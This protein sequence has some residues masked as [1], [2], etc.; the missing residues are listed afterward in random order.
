MGGGMGGGM[1]G[2]AGGMGGMGGMGGGFARR[3]VGGP[4]ASTASAAR[5]RFI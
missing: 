1:G 4:A 3:S 2:M 5:L